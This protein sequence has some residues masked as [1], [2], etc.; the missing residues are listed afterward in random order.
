MDAILLAKVCLLLSQDGMPFL[1]ELG[2][3]RVLTIVKVLFK[4]L[5]RPKESLLIRI[6]KL[7]VV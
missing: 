7:K 6:A 3:H 5:K 1:A 2:E 4:L